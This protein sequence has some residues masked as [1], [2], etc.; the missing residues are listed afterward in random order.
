MYSVTV[1]HIRKT[2]L[3]HFLPLYL[4]FARETLNIQSTLTAT[5]IERDGF[6]DKFDIAVA[7]AEPDHELIGFGAWQDGYDLHWGI[8]GGVVCDLYVLPEYRGYGVAP[9]LLHHIAK[10]IKASGGTFLAGQGIVGTTRP[11]RMYQKIAMGFPGVDCILGGK[12][13]RLFADM[14]FASIRDLVK[15][16]PRKEWNYLP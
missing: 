11:E 9:M 2:D 3:D 6:G 8:A 14:K 10:T 13:F 7:E 4:Q 15:G 1:R 16:L 12:A 5:M